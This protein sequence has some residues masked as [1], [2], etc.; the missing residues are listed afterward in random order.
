MSVE[1]EIKSE[2]EKRIRN[3]DIDLFITNGLD[4]TESKLNEKRRMRNFIGKLSVFQIYQND[5]FKILHLVDS[6]FLPFWRNK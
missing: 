3:K 1:Q 2:K 4:S 6:C 5:K